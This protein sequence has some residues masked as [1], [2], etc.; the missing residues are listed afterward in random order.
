MADISIVIVNWN[1]K[2][3]LGE[4]LRSLKNI[5]NPKIETI[6]IDNNSSDG[7]IEMIRTEYPEV[8]LIAN[9][10]NVGFAR[11][12]NQGIY[13]SSGEY[14]LLL[15]PDTEVPEGSLEKLLRIARQNQNAGII[16]P[17]IVYPDGS[18][19]ESVRRFP[20]F[21]DQTLIQLKLHRLL[22]KSR[23][24]KDYLMVDFDYEKTQTV[25]QVMGA[26]FLIPRPIITHLSGL[27]ER[28][29]IWFEEVDFCLKVKNAGRKV[30][31]TPD[32]QI[33]HKQGQSFFQLVSSSRQPMRNA[34]LIKYFYKN[35]GPLQGTWFLI[36]HPITMGL[37][38]L[39]QLFRV[40]PKAI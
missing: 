8:K 20:R 2:E 13:A 12:C 40:K 34:S 29:F 16:G 38:Y 25:D 21:V 7:S 11:A 22:K 10:G 5:S 15:N 14:I 24:I 35:H 26:A 39:T 27:D 32:V 3:Q 37:A 6:V 28:Y 33:I 18:L 17:K 1:V 36:L 31:Y 9:S 23:W 19:Q 30:L 4:C